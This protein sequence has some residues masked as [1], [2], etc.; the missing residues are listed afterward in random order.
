LSKIRGLRIIGDPKDRVGVISLVVDGM[1]DAKVGKMLDFEGIAV[2][3]GH[4]CAQPILARFGLE[5]TVRPSFAFYNTM[6]EV[7]ALVA[8]LRKIAAKR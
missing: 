6:G 8:A 2:R 3:T 1:T 5:S 4:H 7:D